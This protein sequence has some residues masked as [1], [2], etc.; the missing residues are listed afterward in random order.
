MEQQK[1][2][3][4][5]IIACAKSGRSFSSAMLCFLHGFNDR[6]EKNPNREQKTFRFRLL[7]KSRASLKLLSTSSPAMTSQ[8]QITAPPSPKPEKKDE[9]TP[10]ASK[11]RQKKFH[12]H[13]PTV[14]S[15]EQVLN[16]YSCALISDIL[17][18]G[19]LYITKNYFAFY[20]NVFGYVTKLLIPMLTVEKITKEKTARIIPNAVGISTAEE[21]HVFGSLISREN[22]YKYMMKIW[23]VSHK[24]MEEATIEPEVLVTPEALE[25]ATESDS[26]ET[27]EGESDKEDNIRLNDIKSVHY[28]QAGSNIK[29]RLIQKYES[30]SDLPTQTL[31][32]YAAMFLLLTLT[33]SATLILYRISKIH[34]E[35]VSLMEHHD[36]SLS[37][38]NVYNQL[39]RFSMHLHSKSANSMHNF[40]DSNLH[41]ISKIRQ[42]L[43]LLSSL[44]MPKDPLYD[45]NM[46]EHRQEDML[47][48]D[49]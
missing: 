48:N 21:K 10:A 36:P 4:N 1:L 38:E 44:L 32:L 12:R 22:T 18:Q 43:E 7:R 33:L 23:E 31:I 25:L 8:S 46:K 16:Y 37:G 39:L 17:L 40:I 28:H 35:Y 30:I 34:D 9:E 2:V 24:A 6:D 3:K 27:K 15:D 26:S 14:E 45:A 47:S 20:S 49:S 19:H 13:F 5:D 29:R 41:Q 11:S 42:N